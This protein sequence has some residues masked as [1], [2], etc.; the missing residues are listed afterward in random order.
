MK[1]TSIVN[2]KGQIV[3]P[4]WI[5]TKIGLKRGDQVF[6]VIRSDD[7]F[8]GRLARP[9]SHQVAGSSVRRRTKREASV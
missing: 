4:Q 5:R 9:R 2:T 8:E 6:I 1:L 7:T 3:I